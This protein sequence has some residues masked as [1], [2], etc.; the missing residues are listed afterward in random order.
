VVA[1]RREI[2]DLPRGLATTDG[3]KEAA[4]LTLAA[5]SHDFEFEEC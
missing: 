3:A 5:R 2:D 1:R 4:I